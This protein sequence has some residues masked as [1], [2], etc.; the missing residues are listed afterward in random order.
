MAG[1][2]GLGG[3]DGKGDGH[4]AG[5]RLRDVLR[6]VT[7][8]T[9]SRQELDEAACALVL[10]LRGERETP[11]QVLLLIKRILAEAGLQPAHANKAT[12][13]LGDD[14]RLYRDIIAKCIEY[15]YRG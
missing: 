8:G 9:A 12:V 1:T 10:Q 15:Y 2:G 4:V 3:G 7:R 6:G 5:A 14:A 11:E 13:D